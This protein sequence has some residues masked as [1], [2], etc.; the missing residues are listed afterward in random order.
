[1]QLDHLIPVLQV[2]I[3]PVILIS[4]VG[5]LLLSMTNRLGRTIDRSRI[6]VE[7]RR[8]G[9]P[10][11]RQRSELQLDVLWRRARLLRAAITLAGASVLLASVLIIMLF[12]SVLLQWELAMI[13]I[14][15]FTSCMAA[16]IGSMIFF[17]RDIDLSL[18]AL[19]TELEIPADR[20][21][22]SS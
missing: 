2:S 13:I 9:S 18:H 21:G 19:A 14:V 20:R 1:M 11:E 16:V 10:E 6:L 7:L 5:L 3:G 8:S 12:V 17:L 22:D 4:G 15:L